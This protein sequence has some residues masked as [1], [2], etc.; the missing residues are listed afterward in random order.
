MSKLGH[1]CPVCET[2]VPAYL[3]RGEQEPGPGQTPHDAGDPVGAGYGLGGTPDG[4]LSVVVHRSIPEEEGRA[5][6]D[7]DRQLV[8][9]YDCAIKVLRAAKKAV[10]K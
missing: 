6:L 1:T 7:L 10:P 9:G 4:W 2:E 3:P 5:A 8:C